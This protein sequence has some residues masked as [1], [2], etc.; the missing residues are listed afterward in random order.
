VIPER[1][2]LDRFEDLRK[3]AEELLTS[4][5]VSGEAESVLHDLGELAYEL[6]VSYTELE[7]QNQDLRDTQARLAASRS[8]FHDLFDLSP[9][10]SVTLDR[11]ARVLRLNETARNWFGDANQP[12]GG[13]HFF[14]FV[15]A[16]HRGPFLTFI[17]DVF[18][19]GAHRKLELE[20]LCDDGVNRWVTAT[21]VNPRRS[22]AHEA[23]DQPVCMVS[24]ADITSLKTTQREL[25]HSEAQL[26]AI[27]EAMQDGLCIFDI[28]GKLVEVN[29]AACKLLGKDRA[30]LLESQIQELL[31]AQ[32]R[33]LLWQI[34]QDIRY[35]GQY[36]GQPV[37]ELADGLLRHVALTCV[38][39]LYQGKPHTLALVR[40]I[41]DQLAA[42]SNLRQAAVVFERSSEGILITDAAR[43]INLI[44][45]AASAISGYDRDEL[46]GSDIFDLQSGR[47][48]GL[49]E[50]IQNELEASGQWS[51]EV[52]ARRK[53]GELFLAWVSINRV[54]DDPEDDKRYI[55][56]FHD[57]T[58]HRQAEQRI[59]QLAHFDELTGLPNRALFQDRLTQSILHAE[60]AQT[61]VALMFIDLDNFK[62]IN[63]SLGHLAGDELLRE[64]GER[65]RDSVR[66]ED[67]I[68]RMGGDEFTVL[69][70]DLPDAATAQRVAARLSRII[71]EALDQPV[72]RGGHE[73]FTDGSIGVA[74]YPRDA[75][76]AED[77]V[78]CADTAMYA[79][80]KAG[81]G[82]FQFFSARMDAQAKRRL[83]LENGLRRA[84]QL[85]EFQLVYQP[86]VSARDG[87]RVGMEAL[88]RWI[89]DDGQVSE[90][91]E[92]ISVAEETGMIV[93]VGAWVLRE[94]CLQG[95]RW[96][97]QGLDPG[98]IAVNVSSRQLNSG[99]FEQVVDRALA[100]S[101]LPAAHLE[102]EV[103]E[104]VFL[105]SLEDSRRVLDSLRR[106][107]ISVAIDDFGT[108]YSSLGYLKRLPVDKLKIDRSFIADLE[109]DPDDQA[110]V[111]A[112]VDLGKSFDLAVLAEGVETAEQAVLLRDCGCHQL[113]GFW[114]GRPQ[115]AVDVVDAL[116]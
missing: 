42:E 74:I 75:E 96:L 61:C 3:R 67:T 107:G 26:R 102:I 47:D 82:R 9:M 93:P 90:P 79:A 5:A 39:F 104:R 115:A 60:R 45:D 25:R 37:I 40:D 17:E 20:I 101:G 99:D 15:A 1:Q 98:R 64:V 30:R 86:E 69:L 13:T 14:R 54:Q 16:A 28:N 80:K 91:H 36:S 53:D 41:E 46:L 111:R 31:P 65:L 11:Q 27:I 73:M 72:H 108:G 8:E 55:V 109:H 63:D 83:E 38:T 87:S 10:G 95:R 89:R 4:D 78:R 22:W 84:A 103:C 114:F 62:A 70:G 66:A 43:R 100:D 7:I 97:D 105:G 19:R 85:G 58:E 29:P 68:A 76:Q 57:V 35:H 44:N 18:E 24:F 51:G 112:I 113:Q 12:G 56:I 106:R 34:R 52:S 32:T 49:R 116:G 23:F 77:L 48:P 6:Q 110:I 33:E 92:F 59:R 88:L 50:V 71:L 2:R 21:A 94:A 81:K